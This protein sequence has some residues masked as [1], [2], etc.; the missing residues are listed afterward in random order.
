M[1]GLKQCVVKAKV[2]HFLIVYIEALN[3]RTLAIDRVNAAPSVAQES[4]S[5][6]A[7]AQSAGLLLP[8]RRRTRLGCRHAVVIVATYF[9]LHTD[10][11]LYAHT[12]FSD[13]GFRGFSIVKQC[14]EIRNIDSLLEGRFNLCLISRVVKFQP[15]LYN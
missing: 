11:C 2:S 15:L 4:Q 3:S 1:S 7:R 5:A 14:L 6:A 8:Y 12:Y 9:L 10:L 13:A